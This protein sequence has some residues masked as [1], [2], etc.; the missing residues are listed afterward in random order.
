MTRP[1]RA[2][3]RGQPLVFLGA[4]VLGWIGARTALWQDLAVPLTLPEPLSVLAGPLERPAQPGSAPKVVPAAVARPA[5]VAPVPIAPAPYH[6]PPITEPRPGAPLL[7]APLPAF[8]PGGT[9][10]VAA[11]TPQLA[12]THQ[13]AWLAGVAQLPVPLFVRDRLSGTDRTASLI[14]AE[15]RTARLAPTGNG[16][17]WSVDGWLLLRRGGAGLAPGGLP[18]PTYGASQAGAVVRYRLSPASAHRPAL[19][20]RATSALQAPRGEEAALGLAVRPL[21]RLPVSLQA[22]L[23]RTQFASGAVT[24]PAIGLVTELDRFTLPAGL[25]G[26]VYAQ[27]GYVGGS[28]A[29]AYAEGQARIERRV[30]TIGRGE[31]RLGAGAWGGVQRGASRVDVGPGA[32]LDFPL[33][34]GQG[35]I[36]AD[37]RLR[38]AGNAAPASGPA[39][40]LSAGF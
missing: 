17:R 39:I 31:L 16:T 37:W 18:T 20:L 6:A 22:E 30:V 9:K 15:A 11:G 26:E 1:E 25:T 12:G 24:R 4:V 23:R 21:A 19:Y 36:A 40:T 35:R 38:V 7:Q 33:G 34:P 10:A 28:G 5:A 2:T 14:P 8:A 27:A 3:R 32:V 29:T 13:L